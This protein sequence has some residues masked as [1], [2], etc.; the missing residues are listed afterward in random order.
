LRI[1]LYTHTFFPNVG[2]VEDLAH[3]LAKGWTDAG[4]EV[5]V[6]TLT[7]SDQ[8]REVHYSVIRNANPSLKEL[9][10]LV[11]SHDIVHANGTS[12]R[13]FPV[14]RLLS[15]PFT[16]SHHGY[17]LTCIDGAGW[18]QGRP[19]P[20]EPW[21]SFCHHLKIFGF[22]LALIGGFKL[23]VRR[24]VAFLVDA[25][26]ATSNHLLKRQPL[27]RQRVIYNP[28]DRDLFSIKS[29]E[30]A[31][32]NLQEAQTTFTF[33]GRLISE[34]GADDLLYAFNDL[35]RSDVENIG[36]CASTLKII[37]D[38]PERLSLQQLALKL[39]I[40][41][42]VTWGLYT[43]KEFKE[44]LAR[45]GICV[46]PSAWEEPGALIVLELIAMGKPLIVSE[47]GWLSECAGEAC[48]TFPNGNRIALARILSTLRDDRELQ[49]SLAAKALRRIQEFDSKQGIESY[50][51]LFS[52]IL[53][54]RPAK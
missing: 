37:G 16:W 32:K 21:P 4:H 5:T 6:L 45:A 27:P 2:G 44:E 49:L 29:L 36:K 13:L 25:N 39:G 35:C 54:Q 40:E 20:M 48:L 17:Q 10:T 24:A 33:V 38:G 41:N 53:K 50:L 12:I 28:I 19:A 26:V 46:I 7:I 31:E 23:L 8:E 42:Q 52:D 3:V 1:L 9:I 11:R 18:V 51:N 34:K 43:G 47:R 22:R 30:E 15:K 14:S